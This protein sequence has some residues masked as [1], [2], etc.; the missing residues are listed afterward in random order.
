MLVTPPV[1]LPPRRPANRGKTSLP[2]AGGREAKHIQEL[3]VS[4]LLAGPHHLPT[5]RTLRFQP[6]RQTVCLAGSN[7]ISLSLGWF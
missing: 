5:H 1:L 4:E 2:A 7:C 3:S 6:Q